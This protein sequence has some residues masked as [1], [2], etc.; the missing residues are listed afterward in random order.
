MQK[1]PIPTQVAEYS[2][3]V[4]DCVAPKVTVGTTQVALAELYFC[5]V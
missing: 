4:P 5:P 2:W 1:P 3:S